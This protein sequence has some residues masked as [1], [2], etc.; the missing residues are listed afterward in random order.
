LLFRDVCEYAAN[1][2]CNATRCGSFTSSSSFPSIVA[3]FLLSSITVQHGGGGGGGGG[4]GS[5]G[6]GGGGSVCLFAFVQW[7][8]P[9]CEN[10]RSHGH[11]VRRCLPLHR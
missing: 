4:G 7:R 5:G 3:P 2:R 6:G 10:D 1:K 11:A 8:C 9:G